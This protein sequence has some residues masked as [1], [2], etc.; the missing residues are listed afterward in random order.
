MQNR[1]PTCHKQ[2]FVMMCR[3][4]DQSS[5]FTCVDKQICVKDKSTESPTL[6]SPDQNQ[7]FGVSLSYNELVHCG[8]VTPYGGRDLGQHWFR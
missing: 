7:R 6:C 4:V 5:K 8:L 2:G 3:H 1:L